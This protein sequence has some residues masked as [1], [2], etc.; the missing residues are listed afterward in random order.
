VSDDQYAV[1]QAEIALLIDGLSDDVSFVSAL[2]DLGIRSNPPAVDEPPN[3]DAIAAAFQSFDRLIS[4]GLVKLGRIAYVDR[5]QPP[6]RIAPIE[7]VEEP[8]QIV[9]ERVERSSQG[10]LTSTDWAFSCW[11]MNTDSGDV[12]ARRALNDKA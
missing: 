10:A 7:H 6:G 5:T 12:I 2:I 1:T 9:R 4:A 11:L 3:A 8:I